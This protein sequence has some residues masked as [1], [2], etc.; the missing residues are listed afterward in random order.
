V[1]HQTVSLIARHLEQNGIPTVVIGSARDI[2]EHVAVPRFL[3]TDF[4]LGNPAG[5]PWQPDMQKAIVAMALDL[6]VAATAPQ[7][8]LQAPFIWN[9]NPGWRAV[10]NRVTPENADYLRQKGEERRRKMLAK[11]PLG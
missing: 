11:K 3:F 7:T 1:C 9:G 5:L 10:Y 4:P 8:T 6:L 2:V